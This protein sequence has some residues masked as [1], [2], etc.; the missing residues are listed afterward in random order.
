MG[1]A[2]RVRSAGQ[3]Y[4]P[5]CHQRDRA[6][7]TEFVTLVRL[8]SLGQHV[9]VLALAGYKRRKSA[10]TA[11]PIGK[12]SRRTAGKPSD[13]DDILLRLQNTEPQQSQDKWSCQNNRPRQGRNGNYT[14]MHAYTHILNDV[15]RTSM[16]VFSRLI[17]ME[18][19]SHDLF[20]ELEK[21][22]V[23]LSQTQTQKFVSVAMSDKSEGGVVSDGKISRNY[24]RTCVI[25][26]VKE[27][28]NIP[29]AYQWMSSSECIWIKF[30]E[31]SGFTFEIV[32]HLKMHATLMVR[33]WNSFRLMYHSG[34]FVP[35]PHLVAQVNLLGKSTTIQRGSISAPLSISSPNLMSSPRIRWLI[36]YP[37]CNKRSMFVH[38]GCQSSGVLANRMNRN[39]DLLLY[40]DCRMSFLEGINIYWFEIPVF[41]RS[42]IFSSTI[43]LM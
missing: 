17:G 7:V 5:T 28:P 19:I 15:K 43:M 36:R 12:R 8:S 11:D 26:S 27:E 4:G 29:P 34:W 18:S 9:G 38:D 40:L 13:L 21:F 24:A 37:L 2:V 32:F 14:C 22:V 16:H 42:L 25:L 35:R 20:G 23:F 39:L 3:K 30:D 6:D 10:L 41:S 1:F 33:K 31:G